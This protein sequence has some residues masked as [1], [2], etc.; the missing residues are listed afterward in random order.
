MRQFVT[1]ATNTFMEVVRQPIFLLLTTASAAFS[2]FLASIPYFGFGEDPILVK[3]SVLALMLLTGLLGA[4]LSASNTLAREI[5]SGT[6]LSVLAK[7]ISRAQFLFAK[8]TG[9]AAALAVLNYIN[10]IAALTASRMTFDAYGSADLR[11]L[12]IFF[13]ALVI[14][15]AAG[16]FANY[17][18]R[19]P[20][21]SDALFALVLMIT[22]AFLIINALPKQNL[23]SEGGETDWRIIPASVLIL[24]ALW[25]LAGL[26]LACSTRLEMI[27]TLSICSGFFVLGLMSD[28]VFGTRARDGVWWAHIPYAALPNW[29]L[30]WGG[31]ALITNKPIAW[32]GYIGSSLAYTV[33][34]VGA[35]LCVALCLFEDRELS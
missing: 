8:Y 23:M 18:L 11:A 7:P 13:G 16:G 4:V 17:F 28:Y 2:V 12:S 32:G 10:M 31:D 14:A 34:Y 35:A 1:I 21:V 25:I 22:V 30:F 3:Q 20:F 19:R 6:A 24:F 27:A 5:R 33:C 9:L 26:A 29:Q 15:Y